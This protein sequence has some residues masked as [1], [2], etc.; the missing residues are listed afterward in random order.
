[1]ML[2]IFSRYCPGWT[3]VE[4]QDAEVVRDWIEGVVAA[5]GSI[6]S[7]VVAR[8]SVVVTRRGRPSG[9]GHRSPALGQTGSGMNC[10]WAPSTDTS[11]AVMWPASSDAKNAVRAA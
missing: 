3:V 7:A 2:D 11:C 5:A 6:D 1:M 9:G 4:G 10:D 8:T